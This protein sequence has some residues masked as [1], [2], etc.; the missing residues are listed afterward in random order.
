MDEINF[1]IPR[2]HVPEVTN[3]LRNH[4]SDVRN[5]ETRDWI[6][7]QGLTN[8]ESLAGQGG[9]SGADFAGSKNR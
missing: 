7:K 6:Q 3:L 1:K 9:T 2:Q 8:L 4:L 5:T